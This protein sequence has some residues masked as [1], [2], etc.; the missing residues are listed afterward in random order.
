MS[1]A[2]AVSVFALVASRVIPTCTKSAEGQVVV[3]AYVVPA[4][5]VTVTPPRVE[6]VSPASSGPSMVSILWRAASASFAGHTSDDLM[7]LQ[8]SQDYAADVIAG[9][10]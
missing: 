7:Q 2:V 1:V 10:E 8:Q 3:A 9:I 4:Q 5:V 6:L